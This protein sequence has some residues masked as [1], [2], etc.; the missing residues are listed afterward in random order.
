MSTDKISYSFTVTTQGKKKKVHSPASA[1]KFSISFC[2]TEVKESWTCSWAICTSHPQTSA[3]KPRNLGNSLPQLGALGTGLSEAPLQVTHTHTNLVSKSLT[4]HPKFLA[5]SSSTT[6][7]KQCAE[8]SVSTIR[9]QCPSTIP[10][11]FTRHPCRRSQQ[12][13]SNHTEQLNWSS[14]NTEAFHPEEC[15]DTKAPGAHTEF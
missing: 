13:V 12:E 4:H 2:C 15:M 11:I 3:S 7:N 6:E 1:G 5:A 14:H 9:V 10:L 8:S